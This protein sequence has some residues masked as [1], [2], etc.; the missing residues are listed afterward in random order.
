VPAR[1]RLAADSC[2]ACQPRA[3]P[4]SKHYV[5]PKKIYQ[6]ALDVSL[7]LTSPK[8]AGGKN[9]V[10]FKYFSNSISYL[11]KIYPGVRRLLV[12]H[13]AFDQQV[14][15]LDGVLP[16]LLDELWRDVV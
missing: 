10:M 14:Q 1:Y 11:G 2:G 7:S 13:Q 15:P 9:R 5:R 12:H 16:I 8:S 4:S 3:V 6:G